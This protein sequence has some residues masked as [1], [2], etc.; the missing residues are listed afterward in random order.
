[1]IAPSVPVA[2]LT[3]KSRSTSAAPL[4]RPAIRRPI[5]LV[6]NPTRAVTRASVRVEDLL[7]SL[8]Q[9]MA[10]DGTWLAEW[11]AEG[12]AAADPQTR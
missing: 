1:M 10:A 12:V 6:R 11:V 9:G 3:L 4:G 5:Y 8:L 7:V 2:T